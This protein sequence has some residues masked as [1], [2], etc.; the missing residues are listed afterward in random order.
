MEFFHSRYH[1][2][3]IIDTIPTGIKIISNLEYGMKV[4]DSSIKYLS[5]SK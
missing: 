1:E 2:K 5:F 3:R 4:I